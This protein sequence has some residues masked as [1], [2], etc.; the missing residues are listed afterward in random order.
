V[1]GKVEKDESPEEAMIREFNEE[2][3]T[4]HDQWTRFLTLNEMNGD[5]VY[6][7]F[8]VSL[9]VWSLQSRTDESIEVH[10]VRQIHEIGALP[11]LSWLI[12]MALSFSHGEHAQSFEIFECGSNP[13]REDLL[14]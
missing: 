8:S 13:T 9:D 2:A 6:F 11:N 10:P 4:Y 14:G 5:I 1:G 3:G 7:Y 12:P